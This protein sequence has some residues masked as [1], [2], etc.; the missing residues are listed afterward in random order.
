MKSP[1]SVEIELWEELVSRS[2]AYLWHFAMAREKETARMMG[3]SIRESWKAVKHQKQKQLHRQSVAYCKKEPN[4]GL[5]Q[6][7]Q[8]RADKLYAAG[9]FEGLMQLRQRIEI[10]TIEPG[11]YAELLQ[12]RHQQLQDEIA[13]LRESTRRLRVSIIR[14]KQSFAPRSL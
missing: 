3:E 14:E 1:Q 4:R 9:D 12:E 13:E 2:Y 11:A 5:A 8:E 6:I 10:Q 7:W